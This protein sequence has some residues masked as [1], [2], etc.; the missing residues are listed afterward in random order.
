[1]SFSTSSEFSCTLYSPATSVWLGFATYTSGKAL[2]LYYYFKAERKAGY[3]EKM[4]KNGRWQNY[5]CQERLGNITHIQLYLIHTTLKLSAHYTYRLSV[6]FNI[7]QGVCNVTKISIQA[8]TSYEM[9]QNAYHLS[10]YICYLW[11]QFVYH[12]ISRPFNIGNREEAGY[13]LQ[14]HY[15]SSYWT[16]TD[17][18]LESREEIF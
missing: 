5:N 3:I 7:G 12:F 10:S 1:M 15:F 4:T 11:L 9:V 17:K 14:T 2:N 18:C 8:S 13:K 6:N 16:L